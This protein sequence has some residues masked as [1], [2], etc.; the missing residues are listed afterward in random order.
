MGVGNL[1]HRILFKLK[2]VAEVLVTAL[3]TVLQFILWLDKGYWLYKWS[4]KTKNSKGVADFNCLTK[5][6]FV[7]SVEQQ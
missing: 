7:L 6:N 2:H 5:L 3:P 4:L 1:S